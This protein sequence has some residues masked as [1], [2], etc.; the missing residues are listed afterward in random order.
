MY[1]LLIVDDERIIVEG[2]ANL[3]ARQSLPD[4]EIYTAYNGLEAVELARKQRI[5]ILLSDISMPEMDGIALQK[6]MSRCWPRCRVVFLSGYNDFGYV[7]DSIRGGAIDYV[8]KT[9]GDE[10][11]LAAVRKAI[12]EVEDELRQERLL[13]RART[14]LSA[15]QPALRKEYLLE[16]LAGAPST[17]SSRQRRF[18]EL[19]IP[20]RWNKPALLLAGRV[21]AWRD[22]QQPGDREL[23]LYSVG[24]MFE[25]FVG[26]VYDS[27]YIVHTRNRFLWLMQPKEALSGNKGNGDSELPDDPARFLSGMAES[28]QEACLRFL[29]LPCSFIVGTKAVDWSALPSQMDRIS[30]LFAVGL[31]SGREVLLADHPQLEPE[32]RTDRTIMNR[33]PLLGQ[34]LD[35]KD[36]EAFGKL[37]SEVSESV[38]EREQDSSAFAYKLE[39]FSSISAVF[40]A[41]L[42]RRGLFGDFAARLPVRKLFS[43]EEHDHWEG[44]VGFFAEAAEL[45]FDRGSDD[46]EK[47]A[48]RVVRKLHDYIEKHLEEPLSL[49][50]LADV[51]YLTPSYLSR[52]YK[53]KTGDNMTDYI[54]ERKIREAKRMLSESHYQIQVIGERIG[55]PSPS[56]FS[57]FFKR[58]TGMTPQEFR[59]AFKS[60]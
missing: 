9:E 52:L 12:A 51:V 3:F 60:T 59:D 15:A 58:E 42:N 38:A 46:S 19:G 11:I 7:Q 39:A 24:N 25:E 8:L 32:Q 14:E 26:S 50:Q 6:E 13:S 27:V 18:E 57:R 10:A 5:D 48:D 47:E 41:Y 43:I 44:A 40:A 1:R 4:I 31:G 2:L 35:D 56:Y 37:L 29:K 55:Y 20:L 23:F 21:D 34:Y 54:I 53:R 30:F 33:I 16:L 17:E 49:T 28:L 22:D 45:I 36:R